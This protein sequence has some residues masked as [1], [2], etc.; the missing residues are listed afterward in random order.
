M[1]LSGLL[2]GL[3]ALRTLAASDPDP[4][5]TLTIKAP[6]GSI[7]AN[8][9]R[10]GAHITNLFV[11][12]KVGVFRDI[13]LGYDDRSL[14]LSDPAHPY[15]GPVVG[16]YANR[17]KNATFTLPGGGTFHTGAN[18]NHGLDT[19]HG[20]FIGFDL[21]IWNLTSQ[22]SSSLTFSLLDPNGTEGFPGTVTTTVT[23][24]LQD[25][26]EWKISMSARTDSETPIMLSSHTYWNLDAYHYSQDVSDHFLQLQADQFVATDGILIPTGELANVTGTPLDF[27]QPATL[28]SRIPETSGT[29]LCGTGCVGFDNC[30]IYEKNT[31]DAAPKMSLWSLKS[32]IRLDI[33]T[34]QIA[35]QVYTCNGIA[36]TRNITRKADHGG[37]NGA[38][39]ADHSC[40]VL[41]QQSLIDAINNP[42]WGVN[43]FVEPKDTYEWN[44]LYKFSIVKS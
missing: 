7:T 26:A 8:F 6:D 34:D 15:F 40:V 30:W 13:I 36:A 12:D 16:R 37:S 25:N 38:V 9:I 11:K 41:E 44:S 42:Q 20:G 4:F 39:Y 14:Y 35:A 32:G 17:I 24:A 1:L 10:A 28:G 21:H 19:L 5:E 43:Q 2:V 29:N 31:S 33:L 23:Y 27:R 22:S 3:L 18:E